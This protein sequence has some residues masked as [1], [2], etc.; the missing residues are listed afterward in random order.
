[1]SPESRRP[2]ITCSSDDRAGRG[3]YGC[4]QRGVSGDAAALTGKPRELEFAMADEFPRERFSRTLFLKRGT[5]FLVGLGTAAA[6]AGQA[7]A[8]DNL[9]RAVVTRVPPGPTARVGGTSFLRCN[10][11]SHHRDEIRISSESDRSEAASFEGAIL[12]EDRAYYERSLNGYLPQ[13]SV[14]RASD[15]CLDEGAV[16]RGE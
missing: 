6:V 7:Q 12:D 11:G 8:A 5:T 14:C 10:F 15:G 3:V 9:L 4:A 16:P 2:V 1:M 13:D